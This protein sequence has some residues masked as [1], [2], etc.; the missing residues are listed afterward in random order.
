[1]KHKKVKLIALL[2][3]GITLTGLQAQETVSPSGGN[4]TGAGGVV[5]YTIGQIAYTTNSSV[6]GKVTQGVQQPYEI[7]VVNTVE[8]AKGVNLTCAIYPNPSTDFLTLKIEGNLQT[9]F[10][11]SLF[12]I[13]GK[14]LLKKDLYNSETSINMISFVPSIYFLK[15]TNV[16]N[17][18]VKTFKI[19][20]N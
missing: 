10:N 19:I 17:K 15:V 6:A 2:L 16:N 20:K 8:E 4:A 14:L 13:N 11:A 7:F 18:E 12:D 1:M 9:Q 5:S 3:L